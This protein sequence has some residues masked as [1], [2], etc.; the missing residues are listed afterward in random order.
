M[1]RMILIPG[2]DY[3]GINLGKVTP[4]EGLPIEGISISGPGA[5]YGTA[6]YKATLWPTFTDERN[7]AWS[8]VSG[9]SYAT[10]SSEGRLSVAAGASQS[11]VSIRCAS[12]DNPNIYADKVV[13]C[14]SGTLVYY[15]YIQGDG[16]GAYTAIDRFTELVGAKVTTIF[17]VG[18]IANT[19]M[20]CSR[21]VDSFG[22]ANVNAY[23]LQSN[24]TTSRAVLG[25][26]NAQNITSTS[27]TAIKYRANLNMSTTKTGVDGS[28]ICYNDTTDTQLVIYDNFASYFG[29]PIY[30]FAIHTP[31]SGTIGQF[32]NGKFYRMIIE[33]DEVTLA[34]YRACTIDNVP[35]IIDYISG[36]TYYNQGSGSFTAGND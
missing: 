20:L 12:L 3:S 31:S 22:N 8:I 5:A 15:D 32:S 23:Y 14:S 13:L 33:K 29:A 25:T 6:D 7:V 21:A 27:A 28:F 30:V 11:P 1:G 35:C 34:D 4:N 2:A 36:L 16:V 9:D 26:K 19:Y 10:I 18:N 17:T 24:G